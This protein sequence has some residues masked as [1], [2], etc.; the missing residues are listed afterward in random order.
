MLGFG[1]KNT[2]NKDFPKSIQ[3]VIESSGISP[4]QVVLHAEGHNG[5]LVL[6]ERAVIIGREGFWKKVKSSSFTK[7]DKSIPYKNI[8]GV[9]F[10]EPGL[11]AGYIQF[12]VPGGIEGKGG[13]FNAVS[14]E[15]TVTI[16]GKKQLEDF[17]MIRDF[18]EEKIHAPLVATPPQASAPSVADELG[19]LA[20]LKKEGLISEDEYAQ[21]KN[22]LITK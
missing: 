21:L 19:K 4:E 7:G 15:N 10:K 17:R 16:A 18:V 14:D 2:E 13:V 8:M 20:A 22:K 3:K 6:T 1:K 5:Q 9:Q 11:T 12:T